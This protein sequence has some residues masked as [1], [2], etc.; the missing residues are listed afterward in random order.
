MKK[1][2]VYSLFLLAVNSVY[3]QKTINDVFSS[4]EIIWYGLDFSYARF[5]SIY[6]VEPGSGEDI[7]DNL[8]PAWNKLILVEPRKYDLGTTFNKGPV[9]NNIQPVT[10]IN[11]KID[12]SKIIVD[13]SYRFENPEEVIASA[14]KRYQGGEHDSGLGLVFVIES[15]DKPALE[16]SLYIVFFDITSREVLLAQRMV[17]VPVGFGL[18]NHWAGGIYAILKQIQKTEYKAW[19]KKYKAS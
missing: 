13:R 16:A 7:R 2:L 4:G 6:G 18:R 1:L 15:F 14:V 5:N 3:A 12:A 8:M 19:Q 11:N 17:G 9:E 10:E